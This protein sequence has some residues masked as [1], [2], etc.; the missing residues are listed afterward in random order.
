MPTPPADL[1]P[2][3][4]EMAQET[5]AASRANA[6][7]RIA[8]ALMAR[9]AALELLAPVAAER[10]QLARELGLIRGSRAYQAAVAARRSASKVRGRESEGDWSAQAAGRPASVAP[11]ATATPDPHSPGVP[12]VSVIMPVYNKGATLLE[13]IASVTAQTL[14][15]WEL[16]VWDDGSNDPATVALLDGLEAPGLI[17]VRAANQGVI[18]A[19]NSAIARSRGEFICCLDPDDLFAPTYLEKAVLFLETHPDTAL[20]FPYQQSFGDSTDKWPVPEL[21][22]KVIS[23]QNSVP[24]CA[25]VRR[26]ALLASGGFNPAMHDGCEDWELWAHLAELGFRG[27]PLQEYLFHYR[28]SQA[29][30]RD[31]EARPLFEDHRRRIMR[32]HPQLGDSA[33]PL[34]TEA[35]VADPERRLGDQPWSMPTGEERPVVFFVPWLTAEGGA[36]AFLRNLAQHLVAQGRV[37]VFVATMHPPHLA[38]DGVPLFQDITPYVYALP[39]FLEPEHY[40]AFVRSVLWRLH[41]PVVVN[42]GCPWVYEHLPE[43]R[44]SSRGPAYVVDVLFNH[45]GHMPA[46]VENGALIEHTVVAHSSL[47]ELLTQWFDVPG[48][49]TTLPVGIDPTGRRS[50]ERDLGSGGLPVVGWLGRMS[51]EKQP[52]WFVEVA[53]AL[54]GLASFVMAGTG[55]MLPAVESIGDN[56]ACLDIVGFVDDSHDFL[57]SCDLLVNTSSIEGI[58]VVAMEAIAAGLPVLVTDVGGMSDLVETGVN[59]LVIDARSPMDV[60]AALRELLT[61]DGALTELTQSVRKIGLAPQFTSRAMYVAWDGV[62]RAGDDALKA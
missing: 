2:R 57:E 3:L 23:Q 62:L 41:R 15:A 18:G 20:V 26:E 51:E 58:S 54:D 28:Y 21:H 32:L 55:P 35:W 25:L 30:G 19:R 7:R 50:P 47:A 22:P 5:A 40:P 60:A 43:I 36:E 56:V 1:P 13:S 24:V 11:G 33:R 52:E 10:D 8:A 4:L 16:I 46:N 39:N 34:R 53:R 61:T 14:P 17:V 44:N 9:D 12:T 42:V 48:E 27:E 38:K 37:V 6:A 59:G 49:V 31:S 29:E 45:V